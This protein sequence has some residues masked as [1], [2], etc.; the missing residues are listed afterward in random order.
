MRLARQVSGL[1]QREVAI[2]MGKTRGIVTI[3]ENTPNW[4]VKTFQRWAHALSL[5]ATFEVNGLEPLDTADPVVAAALDRRPPHP[6]G[7]DA[8]AVFLLERHLNQ[9]RAVRHKEP[10]H[11]YK[12]IRISDL[13][14]DVRQL[15][16]VLGISLSR[17]A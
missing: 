13:Q 16:G 17:V 2:R 6:L 3:L 5:K 14:R 15:G 11:F 9:I 7:E 12:D 1:S 10:F 4:K 8:L